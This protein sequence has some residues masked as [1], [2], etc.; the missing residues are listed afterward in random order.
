MHHS[1]RLPCMSYRPKALGRYDPTAAVRFRN[2]PFA[3]AP[4]GDAPLKFA[5]VEESV[6][7]KWNTV[8]V[9]ARQAYSHSASVGRRYTRPAFLSAGKSESRRQNSTAAYHVTLSTG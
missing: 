8:V 6:L 5:C 2:G 3:A 9:P 7:P 1:W 4:N